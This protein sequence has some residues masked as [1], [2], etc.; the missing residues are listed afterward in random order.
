MD[1][2]GTS[3]TDMMGATRGV[4]AE[5]ALGRKITA[6]LDAIVSRMLSGQPDQQ[7][8]WRAAKRVGG[9]SKG[10]PVMV[11]ADQPSVGADKGKADA[12]QQA[13]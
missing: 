4:T 9:S 1:A 6:M 12:A 7:E 13:A 3:R 11:T 10:T 8:I 2:R 5:I